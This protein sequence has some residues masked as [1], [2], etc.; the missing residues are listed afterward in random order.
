M[1]KSKAFSK[2]SPDLLKTPW[3]YFFVFLFSNLLLSYCHLSIEASLWVGLTGLALPLLIAWRVLPPPDGKKPPHLQEFLPPVAGWIWA[4]TIG[5]A[6]FSR[7]YQLTSLSVWP[8]YDEGMYGSYAAQLSQSWNWKFFFGPSQAP[9]LYL[10]GLALL[11]KGWGVSLFTLWLYPAILSLITVPVG[12]WA[13]RAFFS[14]SFSFFCGTLLAL[15]FWPLYTGRLGVMTGLVLLVEC[16]ALGCLGHFLRRKEGGE[17]NKEA[18]TLGAVTG[19]GFYTYLHWPVMAA[20]IAIPVFFFFRREAQNRAPHVSRRAGL[21]LAAGGLVLAPL[22]VAFFREGTGQIG[23]YLK[24][25]SATSSHSFADQLSV[26]LSYAGALFWGMDLSFHTY[27]PLWGGYLN[28]LLGALFFL[29]LLESIRRWR[30]PL[31]QWLL[32]ALFLFLL[33]GLL[34]SERATSRMI[35]ALPILLVI[36]VFGFHRLLGS[37]K[38]KNTG[39]AWALLVLSF[40]L[41][42]YHLAGGYGTIW[43]NL[44]HWKGYEKSY[45]RYQAYLLLEKTAASDGPGLIFNDFVPSLA[46]QTLSVAVYDFNA[47]Q[48]PKRSLAQTRWAAV[49]TNVNYRPFLKARFPDGKAYWISK[50]MN[51]PDGGWMLWLFPATPSRLE[52]LQRWQAASQALEP[53]IHESLC[54]V[55]GNSFEKMSV[56]LQKAYPAFQGDSFLESCFWEKMADLSTRQALAHLTPSDPRAVAENLSS[57]VQKGYPAAHLFRN[58]GIDA[59]RNNDIPRARRHFQQA[60]HAPLNLTDAESALKITSSLPKNLPTQGSDEPRGLNP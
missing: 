59:W 6:L 5:I 37:S 8:L 51:S 27:Q 56:I 53:F 14:K 31:N 30:E 22:A 57:A 35:L 46:D 45:S 24:H 36:A 17:G 48:N 33:P 50:E 54:Y 44:D 1:K 15:G 12:F 42:F 2:F 60:I 43:K 55:P 16:L 39:L 47:A 4:L 3:F 20:A 21:F 11:F 41:D 58:L 25:L 52:T 19:L 18:L 28:P 23:D 40:G 9:P 10:W 13:A 32:L 29:G 49:I 26:S 34:T 7:F 38:T